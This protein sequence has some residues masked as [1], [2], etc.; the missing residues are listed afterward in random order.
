MELPKRIE[1]LTL[2]TVTR[3]FFSRELSERYFS[4]EFPMQFVRKV[5]PSADVELN[6]KKKKNENFSN[7]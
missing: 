7:F 2:R 5:M 3:R 1:N 4:G 6:L